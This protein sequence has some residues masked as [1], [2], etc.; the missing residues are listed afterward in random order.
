MTKSLKEIRQGFMRGC[1][2]KDDF[3]NALRAH[4]E[5][6]DEMRSDQRDAAAAFLAA[7]R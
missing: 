7:T 1:V 4:K 2:T 5:S 3:E 6:K